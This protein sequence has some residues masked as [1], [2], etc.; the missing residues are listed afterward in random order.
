MRHAG[1]PFPRYAPPHE[2]RAPR[3]SDWGFGMTI[4]IAAFTPTHE[5]VC[6]SDNMLSMAGGTFSNDAATLKELMVHPDWA[7]L[8]AADDVGVV[9]RLIRRIRDAIGNNIA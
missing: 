2:R 8:F 7:L 3:P 5:I 6:V 4:C 9:P 1:P